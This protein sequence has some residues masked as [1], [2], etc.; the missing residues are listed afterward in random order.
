MNAPLQ[1][2]RWFERNARDLPWRRTHDPYRIWVS[3]IMLQ[4]TQVAAVI[5]Y[6]ERFLSQLP[7]LVALAAVKENRLMAL[8]SGLGYYSRARNLQKGARYLVERGG[9]PRTR[10]EMLKVPGIGPYTAGA[11]LSIAYDLPVPL[12]DGNVM[13]VLSRFL[14]ERR[15]IETKSVQS[16]F[17]QECETWVAR[18]KSPRVF[19]QALMELGAAVCT[20][21]SPSCGRCPLQK[22]CVALAKGWTDQLPRRKPKRAKVDL[23]WVGVIWTHRGRV[24]LKQNPKGEWWEGLWDVPRVEVSSAD[25]LE[26]R[27]EELA[28]EWGEPEVL[29]PQKHAVTHHRIQAT[30]AVWRSASPPFKGGKWF[31]LR[32][33]DEMP[34]SALS[35]KLLRAHLS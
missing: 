3:E 33:L 29:G 17:W 25:K 34:V 21:T 19:N 2:S 22:D 35:R 11:V 13:R 12:V 23:C 6:Y 16:R 5:P 1:L 28:R 20:R 24:Y 30:P 15:E 9:F 8:W 7:T 18:C 27:L 32:D 4:Q 10:E 26:S 14:G 31:S